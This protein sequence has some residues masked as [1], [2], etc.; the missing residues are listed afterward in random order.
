MAKATQP[1]KQ[2]A[3]R[4]LRSRQPPTHH[5]HHHPPGRS[6]RSLQSCLDLREPE[7]VADSMGMSSHEEVLLNE[8]LRSGEDARTVP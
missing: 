5:H 8:S 1:R 6:L 4:P 3:P 7:V 2:T